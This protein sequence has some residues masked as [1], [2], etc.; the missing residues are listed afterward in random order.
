MTGCDIKLKKEPAMRRGWRR[1]FYV[2]GRASVK[3]QRQERVLLVFACL[4]NK[5]E[6]EWLGHGE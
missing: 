6:A 1:I 2:E 5:K 3:V 4:R